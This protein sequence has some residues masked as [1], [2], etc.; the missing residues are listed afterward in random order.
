MTIGMNIT[1][2]NE[3][4]VQIKK[5]SNN[6]AI[7]RRIFERFLESTILGCAA[8]HLLLLFC[9]FHSMNKE[10]AVFCGIVT[11][12]QCENMIFLCHLYF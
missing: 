6:S 12:H 1:R 3:K 11:R 7:C 5:S 8:E 9:Y 10:P 4:S 2:R